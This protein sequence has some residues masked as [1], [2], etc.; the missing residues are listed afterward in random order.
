MDQIM[1]NV[2]EYNEHWK[3]WVAVWL[4]GVAVVAVAT[5]LGFLAS[6]TGTAGLFFVY[7]GF[8]AVG[9][10]HSARSVERTSI[11]SLDGRREAVQIVGGAQSM[12]DPFTAP[13]TDTDCVAWQLQVEEY[14]PSDE[15]GL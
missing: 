10:W 3:R 15:E 9:R 6:L 7:H 4:V 8:R 2:G 14:S 5:P 1:V 11:G 12:A 13:L